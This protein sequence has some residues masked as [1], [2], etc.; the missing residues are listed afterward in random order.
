MSRTKL[1]NGSSLVLGKYGSGQFFKG[2][3]LKLCS[4]VISFFA[5]FS[6]PTI[7]ENTCLPGY[8]EIEV[9]GKYYKLDSGT[10]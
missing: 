4:F 2:N 6:D 1:R 10:Q 9:A 7:K 5:I 8:I 3:C